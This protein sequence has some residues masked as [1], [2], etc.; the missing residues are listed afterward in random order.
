MLLGL[1]RCLAA[2]AAEGGW[3]CAQKGAMD[4]CGNVCAATTPSAT[5]EIKLEH[6][7][8][9]QEACWGPFHCMSKSMGN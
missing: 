2:W 3:D 8:Y 1:L 4:G 9:T 6:M 5:T 7:P